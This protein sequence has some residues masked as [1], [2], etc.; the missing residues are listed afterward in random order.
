M[1]DPDISDL[2]DRVLRH[3]SAGPE[4]FPADAVL[5]NWQVAC[6]E[7]ALKDWTDIVEEASDIEDV[8]SS[9]HGIGN[10]LFVDGIDWARVSAFLYFGAELAEW[11]GDNSVGWAL[12]TYISRNLSSWI[13]D[14]GGWVRR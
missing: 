6:E 10:A 1:V 7:L 5:R 11:R 3:R 4:R 12:K 9:I 2:V 13:R 8:T 14:H